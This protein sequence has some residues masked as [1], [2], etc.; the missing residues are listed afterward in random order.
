MMD[1]PYIQYKGKT[2]NIDHEEVNTS[3]GPVGLSLSL[4]PSLLIN[5]GCCCK[6]FKIL[7]NTSSPDLERRIGFLT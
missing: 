6:T 3:G 1:S 7:T 4:F 2:V 5:Y